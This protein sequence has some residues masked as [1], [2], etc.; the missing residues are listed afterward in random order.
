MIKKNIH[1]RTDQRNRLLNGLILLLT[2]IFSQVSLRSQGTDQSNFVCSSYDDF[3]PSGLMCCTPPKSRLTEVVIPKD[4]VFKLYNVT[5]LREDF[6]IFRAALEESHPGLYW[7]TPKTALDHAFDSTYAAISRP[8]NTLEYARLIFPIVYMIGCGHTFSNLPSQTTD[9]LSKEGKFFP[10]EIVFKNGKAYVQNNNS[11]NQSIKPGDEI[12]EIDHQTI[13]RI[14]K[15]LFQFI[16]AD[17][18]T[19]T[20]KFKV[21]KYNFADFYNYYIEAVDTFHIKIRTGSRTKF[22]NIEALSNSTIAKNKKSSSIKKARQPIKLS[23]KILSLTVLPKKSIAILKV[24]NFIDPLIE[25][26]GSKFGIFIDSAFTQIKKQNAKVLIIDIRG[27]PGGSSG[28]SSTLFSYL[29]DIPFRADQYWEVKT[30]P[31]PYIDFSGIGDS[32]GNSIALKKQDFVEASNGRY[33]LKHYP[34]YDTILPNINRFDGKVYVLIDGWVGSEAAAFA[35]LVHHSRRGTFVGEETGGNY[36]GC[37][38]GIL[39]RTV[40]PTTKLRITIPVFKIVRFTGADDENEGIRP[41]HLV[42]PSLSDMLT[43]IDREM[44]FTLDLVY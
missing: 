30:L 39:G 20:G 33:R 36:N 8:M 28:N 29:T 11:N 10:F 12:L 38:A 6:K 17:N 31:L 43:D 26:Q 32:E 24:R 9:Y 3:A 4:S 18:N 14:N 25:A 34:S 40:L 22:V 27:N 2:I 13:D 1:Y 42:A 21:L 15:R 44:I 19:A 7:H 35:S 5:S 23:D 37:T 41:D 16:S